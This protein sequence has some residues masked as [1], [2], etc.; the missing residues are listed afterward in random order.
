MR[1]HS[2][3]IFLASLLLLGACS[4]T[5][6]STKSADSG[7]PPA[8]A[9][10]AGVDAGDTAATHTVSETNFAYTP[11]ELTIKVGDTVEWVW[12]EGTH[13]VSSGT[14]CVAD[15]KIESGQH[16]A[17]FTFTHTFT[18]PG[19]MSYLCAYMEHCAKGQTGVISIKAK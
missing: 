1:I 9:E 12:E 13:T 16:A 4:S 10:E 17:P 3:C 19:T 18:E 6:S 2:L 8:P 11:A 5:T 15:K 14:D 7:V